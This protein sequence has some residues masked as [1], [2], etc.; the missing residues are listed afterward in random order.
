MDPFALP[1]T[2][3]TS[4]GKLAGSQKSIQ[5][6]N[7]VDWF[8]KDIFWMACSSTEQLRA[9]YGP[10][11]LAKKQK[12]RPASS[13]SATFYATNTFSAPM[14]KSK[15]C[16]RLELQDV[17]PIHRVTASSSTPG[18]RP[19]GEAAPHDRVTAE[20]WADT[21]M[22]SSTA[23]I[24]CGSSNMP[25]GEGLKE[26]ADWR[27]RAALIEL[28]S[29]ATD[30][31]FPPSLTLLLNRAPSNAAPSIVAQPQLSHRLPRTVSPMPGPSSR[32]HR[33]CISALTRSADL[34]DTASCCNSVARS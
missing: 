24:K 27:G 15:K 6:E 2:P 29:V 9:E 28:P 22:N 31:P 20:V 14:K 19:A 25:R 21:P 7:G 33:Q 8:H 16:A 30:H 34:E 5:T 1:T 12:S 4:G 32:M 11:H 13:A 26:I 3:L 10:F 18:A 17:Q 23:A